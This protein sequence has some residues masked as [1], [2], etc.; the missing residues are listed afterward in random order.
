[1]QND[2]ISR[3]YFRFFKILIF[4][5][6]RGVKEQKIAQ[7]DKKVCLLHW[8]SWEPYIIWWSFVV[9]ECKMIISP[10]SFFIFSK[11]W[12]SGLLGGSKGKKWP[13][14]TKTLSFISQEPYIIWSWFMVHMCKRIIFPGVFYIVLKFEFSGSI[15]G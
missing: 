5:V 15:L 2:N 10:D 1:M 11:L 13:K 8:I 4:Q 6:V 12:F 14:I 7:N 3:S 9:H